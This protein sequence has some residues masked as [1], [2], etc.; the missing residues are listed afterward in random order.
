[1]GKGTVT[2]GGDAGEYG[3]SIVYNDGDVEAEVDTLGALIENLSIKISAAEDGPVK[4]Y[5]KLLKLSYE[6]RLDVLNSIP[7]TLALP[8]VWCADLTEDLTGNVGII[9]VPG[10]STHF[11]IQPGY[12]GNA[13]YNQT[14][15]GQLTP[16]LAMTPPQAFYNLAMLPGWQKW[17]PTY[18]YGTIT[19]MDD[20]LA[21]VTLDAA[22]SSQQNIDINQSD[23]ISDVPIDY[24]DCDDIA[25]EVGD[26]VIV[27]FE[28]QSFIDPKIIGF[29]DHPKD[30]YYRF[31]LKPTFNGH[32]PQQGSLHVV[33]SYDYEG[34]NYTQ[35]AYVRSASDPDY[36][37]RTAPFFIE[38]RHVESGLTV[39]VSLSLGVGRAPAYLLA[40][41]YSQNVL[42]RD[43]D[44][45]LSVSR[46]QE[47]TF[48]AGAET[49]DEY[50]CN[51][52]NLYLIKYTPSAGALAAQLWDVNSSG[53]LYQ[54]YV[55]RN[56]D[57][58]E[59][60]YHRALTLDDRVR[61]D[62][63]TVLGCPR[64][65]IT[66]YHQCLRLMSMETM[67]RI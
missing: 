13:A 21:A 31:V 55:I 6:K 23:T 4:S 25:F 43:A 17:R 22:T 34:T 45:T 5:L 18:R 15:D 54:G 53:E 14:R 19:A 35:G 58:R 52:S 57:E 62:A 16:T 7:E 59:V 37:S 56:P 32:V 63:I 10:E 8:G 39:T 47:T 67:Y 46:G 41:D 20:G 61:A 38:N 26:V 66:G 42:F 29:K 60:Q 64:S 12:G 48:T 3:V 36:P 1:M 33:I 30:C 24:M 9:E 40:S 65:L 28:N 27:K 50:S 51:I 11:N 44:E 2:S 49:F